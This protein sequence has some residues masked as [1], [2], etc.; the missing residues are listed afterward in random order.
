MPSS[1]TRR[2]SSTVV[3]WPVAVAKSS[4]VAL[5]ATRLLAMPQTVIAAERLDQ[6]GCPNWASLPIDMYANF[7]GK[8]D[9]PNLPWLSLRALNCLLAQEWELSVQQSAQELQQ[10]AH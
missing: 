3:P 7:L 4:R 2:S 5:A 8:A 6:I 10:S 9:P 1:M